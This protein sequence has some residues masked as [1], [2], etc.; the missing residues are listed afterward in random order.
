MATNSPTLNMA[1][2]LCPQP[3]TLSLDDDP[4]VPK[5]IE[6]ALGIPNYNFATVASLLAESKKLNPSAVFID[7]HLP[8]R[9]GL[10][11]I[12]TLR[13]LW[14]YIPFIVVTA[15]N[16]ETKISEALSLGA[17]DFIQKPLNVTELKARLHRRW[18]DNA[19]KNSATLFKYEDI[20]LDSAHGVLN[21]PK[22]S[23][24][25][26]PTELN[27]LMRLMQAQGTPVSRSE[28]KHSCW[29]QIS[30]TENAL[31][32][33]VYETRKALADVE[34]KLE[35]KTLYGEGFHLTKANTQ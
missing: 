11:L 28:L 25:V 32:R 10:E 35:I 7:I 18:Q 16:N 22:G 13:N 34:S 33:K 21:G 3:Y 31:D 5:L 30:V 24:T 4:L 19:E 8:D 26:S 15:D 17:D 1:E 2:S 14:P 12:P 23:R 9:S 29:Q 20:S 6:G 27:L